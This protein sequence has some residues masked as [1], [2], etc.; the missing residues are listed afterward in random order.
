[1]AVAGGHHQQLIGNRVYSQQFPFTN[2]GLY[3]WDQYD[4]ACANITV[5]DNIINYTHRDGFKNP[6]WNGQNCGVID[7]WSSDNNWSAV[8]EEAI[9]EQHPG[10]INTNTAV[11]F[12][13][14]SS[15]Q[16]PLHVPQNTI[17]NDLTS[18]WSAG[19]QQRVN[20][21]FITI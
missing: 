1:M 6:A 20:N 11:A 18:R 19:G 10:L 4:S 21:G 7:G 2:V 17:D 3:V 15:F 16:S 12:V 13:T 5:K 8:I 14:A 9:A